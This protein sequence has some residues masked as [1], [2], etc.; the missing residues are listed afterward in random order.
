ML[1]TLGDGFSACALLLYFWLVSRWSA[2][3]L[4]HLT[5]GW[6]GG[7]INFSLACPHST[8]VQGSSQ[9]GG[10]GGYTPHYSTTPQMVG[11]PAWLPVH[12]PRK[13]PSRKKVALPEKFWL[14]PGF[15]MRFA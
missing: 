2:A 11:L 4:S 8:P 12:S 3:H 5:G 9:L 10:T 15:C 7:G 14:W 1:F 13:L 6:V